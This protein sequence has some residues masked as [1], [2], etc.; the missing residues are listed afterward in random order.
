MR[1]QSLG[2][3]LLLCAA[4]G[5]SSTQSLTGTWSGQ[6]GGASQGTLRLT[7][8]GSA[9]AGS[10]ATSAGRT[11]TVTGSVT[12]QHFSGAF[13]FTDPCG[14]TASTAADIVS[15]GAGLVGT[16]AGADCLGPTSGGYTL[17][18]Q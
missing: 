14:G 10:L 16:Y 8:T 15:N 3:I 2:I 18:R 17:A 12:A 1:L 4:C 11:A 6:Y 5:G 13:S 7:E 9:V